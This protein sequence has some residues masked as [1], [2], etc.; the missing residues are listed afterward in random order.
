MNTH[1]FFLRTGRVGWNFIFVEPPRVT[2]SVAFLT[3]LPIALGIEDDEDEEAPCPLC[4]A[5]VPSSFFLDEDIEM[6]QGVRDGE[7]FSVRAA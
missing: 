3:R 7:L 6:W 2:L 5:P 4:D 1:S